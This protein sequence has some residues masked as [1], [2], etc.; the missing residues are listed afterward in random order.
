MNHSTCVTLLLCFTVA[1]VNGL[2]V[3]PQQRLNHGNCSGKLDEFLCSCLAQNATIDIHLLPGRYDFSQQTCMLRNKPRVTIT[4]D[5]TNSTAIYCNGFSLVFVNCMNILISNIEM[6]GCGNLVSDATNGSFSEAVPESY[7]GDGSQFTLLFIV[8]VNITISNLLVRYNLG[9]SIIALN[10]LGIVKLSQVHIMNTTFEQDVNCKDLGRDPKTDFSCSGSGILFSYFDLENAPA[11][12]SLLSIDDCVFIGNK[13]IAPLYSFTVFSDVVNTAFYRERVPLIGA[14]CIALYYVQHN[15]TVTTNIS[16]TIFY[17]NNGTYSATV[18]IAHLQSTLGITNF[19]NCTFEDN[20]RISLGVNEMDIYGSKQRGGIV[21]LYF[22]IRGGLTFSPLPVPRIPN[23]VEMLTVSNCSFIKMGG[24]KGAAVYIEKNSADYLTVV[25]RFLQC[26]FIENEGDAGSAIFAEDNKFIVTESGG[27]IQINLTDVMAI[28]NMLSPAGTLQHATS[29]LTTGVFSLHS[30]RAFVN[31]DRLCNFTGNQPSV[32]YGRNSGIVISGTAMFL[33]NTARFGGAFHLLDS[34]IFV[35]TGSYLFF[36]NNFATSSGG[37]IR[38]DFTNTNEQS[39]DY[40]PIQ[41]VG[42]ISNAEKVF[43]LRGINQLNVNIVFES[44][45]A[46]SRTSLQSISSNV[47][48]VCSWYPDTVTQIKLGREA[49]VIN[50]TRASVYHDVLTFIPKGSVNDHLLILADLPCLC[51]SDN[52][53]N[54]GSCL[55]TKSLVLNE[56]VVPGRSFNLSIIALDVV[57]S[58]GF[59]DRLFGDVYHADISDGQLLLAANQY[60]RPF[61]VANNTCTTADFTVFP[62]SKNYPNNGTL[63]LSLLQQFTLRIFFNLNNCS[64][65]F[66]LRDTG[67]GMFGCTCDSFFTERVDRRFSCDAT[68]GN[69]TRHHRQAWL[70]VIDGDLQYARIC[71]PTYCHEDLISFDLSEENILCTNHHS[72]RACGGCEDGFSRVFGSDTCKKCDSAWL[73][74]IVLYAILGIVL[75][76]MLF[77][78][79]FTVTLGTI[80]GVIFFCNVMSINEHLFFNTT[81]S[82]F[83]F[84]R[85]YI[86]IVN[87]DLG[88]ELCFY[89]GMSQ[90]SKTGLQF[91]FPVYLWL[92]MLVIIF[93]AKKYFHDQKISSY[94]A[95]PVLATLTLLS[96]QKILRAIIRVF[97]FTTVSSSSRNNIYVWQPDPTVD[98]LTGH[99]ITLFVIAV[100]F[101][102]IFIFPFVICFTFPSFVLRSKR[103]SYFFPVLDSFVAPYKVKY[104]YWF[105]LRAVLL[106]YLSGMEA[107]IFS[108]PESLLLSS[109]IVVGVFMFAQGYI[110]PYKTT[111]NN[112]TD[113]MFMG[114]FFMIATISLY[115]YPSVYGYEDVNIVVQVFGYLSFAIFFLVVLYHCYYVTRHKLWNIYLTDRAWKVINNYKDKYGLLWEPVTVNAKS[116]HDMHNFT[117][118]TYQGVTDNSG[119]MVRFRESLLEH[120]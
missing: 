4:G 5:S 2:T 118:H 48:Y 36:Q 76:L 9:Y 103:L 21:L 33:N 27:G 11:I 53:Y 69:I 89:E 82:R 70:S 66:I 45:F 98:Y 105:G 63:E 92:L 90:L 43:T 16:N 113:L 115:F 81:I 91:V 18:G 47:F 65:G 32:F 51:D 10:A 42:S 107:I 19:H 99:H 29:R 71:T 8:S 73:A 109:V 50:G 35:H 6:V 41:F 86:S 20:N 94:S 110:H 52:S 24:N 28:N 34:F 58:V 74:T 38:G 119:T 13:N 114:N 12:N 31:C 87:L 60:V 83:S 46:V 61:F 77:L 120:M 7:F 96:Y 3:S 116:D 25:A 79:K 84:L 67:N 68:T 85:V 22:I 40:C 75:V 37:A 80:N 23:N 57:G 59:S 44:N 49:P 54:I 64:E 93:I 112:I 62:V 108:Y 26:R 95:L 72:G 100:V 39:E 1:I 104:R 101:L 97:S 30:C 17:N 78:L 15:F 106:L 111:L 102:L 56:S 117:S 14:G 55:T 88:F